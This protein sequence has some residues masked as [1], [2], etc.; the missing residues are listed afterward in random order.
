MSIQ[1]ER[2]EQAA[3]F[4]LGCLSAE[5]SQ[6][7]RGKVGDSEDLKA[8]LRQLHKTLEALSTLEPE[9]KP[10]ESLKQR[11]MS[12]IGSTTSVSSTSTQPWKQWNENAIPVGHPAG[13]FTLSA[14]R[15]EWQETDCHGVTVR[16]LFLDQARD[17]VTMLVKMAPGSVYPGHEHHGPE[18]C[19]VLEGDLQEESFS[20]KAG[21]YQR[22][23]RGSV[24]G[25]QFSEFGCLLL[26]TSS[27]N[28]R[29]LESV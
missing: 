17:R 7:F 13:I 21:D 24:H 18:E 19:F 10:P 29:L 23:D 25:A 2:H 12:R 16:K 1:D 6:A 22:A 26:I 3:L 9:E 28:D 11:L 4:A 14:E 15:E 20:M 5:E 8:E 27:L